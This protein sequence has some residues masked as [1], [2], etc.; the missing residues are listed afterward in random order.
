MADPFEYDVFLSFS[1]ADEEIVK[2][3]WQELCSNG[4][5][6]FWSDST[7]KKEVGNSW[8]EVIEKSLERSRHMLLVCS[9][10]SMGS[11]W[12]KR[13]YRAFFDYCYSP[14]SRRL[15]P[16]LTR[17][18]PPKNL[19][20]FL[21]ELQVGKISDSNF[22]QEIIPILGGVNIERLQQE[23]KSLQEQVNLL[24]TEKELLR[25]NVKTESNRVNT[26]IKENKSLKE[27]N[28]LLNKTTKEQEKLQLLSRVN[29]EKLQ[30]ERQS[31]KEQVN[32]LS[33]ENK[34][35]GEKAKIAVDNINVLIDDN[36]SL[37][38]QLAKLNKQNH[39]LIEEAKEQNKIPLQESVKSEISSQSMNIDDSKAIE[40]IS[41]PLHKSS[42]VEHLETVEN[43]IK[44]TNSFA[45]NNAP[46][47]LPAISFEKFSLIK[48]PS[49]WY[50]I[51]NKNNESLYKK[52]EN[53]PYDYWIGKYPITNE[54]YSEYAKENNISF[55]IPENK[56]NHP[57]VQVSWF[58]AN[59]FIDWVNTNRAIELPENYIF[60][61]PSADEWKKAAKGEEGYLFPWGNI[62]NQYNCNTSGSGKGDTTPIGYYS[63][64]GDSPYGV[65]DMVGNVEQWT[66]SFSKSN[67]NLVIVVGSYYYAS[68][69]I[70][71]G[72]SINTY[73]PNRKSYAC[74]FRLSAIPV[75]ILS[76]SKE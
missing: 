17:E 25:K 13:E 66:R 62:F 26:L 35:L 70:G 5:R 47:V 4:L 34:L 61:L 39:L 64:H 38:E 56:E 65:S 36:K 42:P 59:K 11:K 19:P 6:V 10:N 22:I 40:E 12:V 9:D 3:I 53:I 71:Q 50:T 46:Q 45:A 41:L 52:D 20:L 32:S 18:F 76:K 28:S 7:L 16:L 27:Q 57:V 69:N 37:K 24:S 33:T 49:G 21:R 48:I 63:P 43:N 1:S 29:I 31:L 58:E 72:E 14:S 68:Q 67:P 55:T 54:Q 51:F 60:T 73:N 44:G 75:S 30:Q 74:G 8:F 15:I 2:P 23:L